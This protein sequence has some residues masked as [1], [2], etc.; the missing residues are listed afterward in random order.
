MAQQAKA[1][2]AKPKELTCV[3]GEPP[4]NQLSSDLDM[5]IVVCTN[6]FPHRETDVI[7]FK[8][9]LLEQV[10]GLCGER[11]DALRGGFPSPQCIN[12]EC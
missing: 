6:P 10:F 4:L 3:L 12:W 9:L 7:N 8:G 1:L 11:G 2:A 5:H